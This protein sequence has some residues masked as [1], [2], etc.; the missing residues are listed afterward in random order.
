MLKVTLNIR[1]LRAAN[2]VASKEEIQFYLNGVNLEFTPEG[3]IICA[4]NGH[5]MIIL[6]Q[7][8]GEHAATGPHQSVIVPRELIDKLKISKRATDDLTVLTIYDDGRLTFE[9]NGEI[10][11]KSRI[12]GTFPNFRHAIPKTLSGEAAQL[13]PAYLM[14][15]EK[16]RK[17]L[18]GASI[19]S[20]GSTPTIGYNGLDSNVVDFAFGTD[21]KA[22]GIIMPMRNKSVSDEYLW[23]KA[24]ASSWTE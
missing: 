16:A 14:S 7:P 2:V 23:A 15:F 11:G 22:I 17:E 21:F 4:T 1:A 24:P 5:Q 18:G 12:D 3:V 20:G 8:Y 10:F 9:Q 19:K 13:N 6:R